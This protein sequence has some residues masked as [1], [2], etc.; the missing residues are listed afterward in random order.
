MYR[1]PKL[2]S[3]CLITTVGNTVLDLHLLIFMTA[4]KYDTVERMF[5]IK[6]LT[7]TV[8]ECLLIPSRVIPFNSVLS[9]ALADWFFRPWASFL[10]LRCVAERHECLKWKSTPDHTKIPRIPSFRNKNLLTEPIHLPTI[11][12]NPLVI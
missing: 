4:L 1:I 3:L 12:S 6:F 5:Q 10:T 7:E 8:C 9:M 11:L 2:F